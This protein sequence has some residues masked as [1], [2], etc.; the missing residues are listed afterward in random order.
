MKFVALIPA[1][2]ASTR[3]PRKLLQP[4]GPLSIIQHVFQRVSN[5][6]L[7]DDVA[8]VTD[9]V[10][11]KDQ[12][13]RIGGVA[14][15]SHI[16]HISGTDRIAEMIDQFD[17]DFFINVQG[18]EPFVSLNT[19]SEMKSIAF[20][21][22]DLQIITPMHS[23]TEMEAENPNFVK[24]VVNKNQEA[25]YFS[26]A[27]IPFPR[28][29]QEG[30]QYFRHIGIYGFQK[31]VLRSVA[32]LPPT[33][34]ENVELLENLRWLEYG[35]KIRVFP[36]DKPGIAIDTMSD[37]LMAKEFYESNTSGS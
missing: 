17:A 27:K 13:E 1:R 31:E 30:L 20:H 33:H 8:V 25:M 23:I 4:L 2:L 14:L 18:D 9:S 34:L 37:Y 7:F 6:D 16:N 11:I 22:P 28:A 12:I 5:M 3:F 15:M 21:T 32:S 35:Y 19:L 24:I 10:E 36:T 29:H 26:R